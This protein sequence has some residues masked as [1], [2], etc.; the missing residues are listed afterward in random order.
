MGCFVNGGVSVLPRKKKTM[1]LV[2]RNYVSRMLR[3]DQAE[4]LGWTMDG[5]SFLVKIRVKTTNKLV[6]SSYKEFPTFLARKYQDKYP[7]FINGTG[8]E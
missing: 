6:Q 7:N 8:N 2:S 5:V 1:K 4:L 3:E